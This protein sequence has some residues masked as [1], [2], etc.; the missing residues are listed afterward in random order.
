MFKNKSSADIIAQDMDKLLQDEHFNKITSSDFSSVLSSS[1]TNKTFVRE[2]SEKDDLVVEEEADDCDNT[3]DDKE[4]YA[5]EVKNVIESLIALSEKLD[6]LGFVKSSINTAYIVEM[7]ISE[8]GDG[9]DPIE[10]RMKS[11]LEDL[12]RDEPEPE[13]KTPFFDM[14][15]VIHDGEVVL[16]IKDHEIEYVDNLS[17]KDS[18]EDSEE[19]SDLSADLDIINQ[20]ENRIQELESAEKSIG[21]EEQEYVEDL[22]N[23]DS[24]QD[25]VLAFKELDAWTKKG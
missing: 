18:E 19:D 1:P 12:R 25:I 6:D 16:P 23:E 15:S 13:E 22:T 10:L 21:T 3:E 7:L 2:A 14:K 8:A 11:L 24:Y 17:A 5:S 20:I 9:S 4:V